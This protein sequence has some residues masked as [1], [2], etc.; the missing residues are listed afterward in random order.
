MQAN[1]SEATLRN[2]QAVTMHAEFAN[3]HL[4]VLSW[5]PPPAAQRWQIPTQRCTV[6]I[7][8]QH[9]HSSRRSRACTAAMHATGG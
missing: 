6:S 1:E 8:E 3:A 5:Q 7:R 4:K 9:E 2:D